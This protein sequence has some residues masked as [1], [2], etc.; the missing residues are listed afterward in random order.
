[1][2]DSTPKNRIATA[3]W[4]NAA[5]MGAILMTLVLRQPSGTFL[6]LALGDDGRPGTLYPPPIAGGGGV[7]LMPAQFSTNVWGCYLMD[8]DKQTLVA[9][10]CSGSP[11]QLRLTAARSFS[12]DLRLKNYNTEK[13][14][15]DEVKKLWE[16]QQAAD[17]AATTMPAPPPA[18]SPA[19]H[20]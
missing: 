1:M 8:I 10:S 6:P 13:P 2:N 12:Y 11:P 20:P 18:E 16:K 4:V 15:P 9:Y 14:W 3:L 19:E 7:F 5:I 17:R